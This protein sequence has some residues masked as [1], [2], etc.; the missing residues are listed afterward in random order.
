MKKSLITASLFLGVIF[1]SAG[2]TYAAENNNGTDY[3]NGGVATSESEVVKDGKADEVA[4]KAVDSS[5][6][7]INSD[8]EGEELGGLDNSVNKADNPE[9]LVIESAPD[10]LPAVVEV[11]GTPNTWVARNGSQYYIGSDG[12]AV[13]GVREINGTL[14]YFED[15]EGALYKNVGFLNLGDDTYYVTA[16]GAL[17]RN[18]ITN[19]RVDNIFVINRDGRLAKGLFYIGQ[20][21]YFADKV[22]GEIKKAAKW[23]DYN[24][25]RYYNLPSGILL[26]NTVTRTR[27]DNMFIFQFGGEVKK[28][29]L[30]HNGNLYYADKDTGEIKLKAQWI[31]CA[32]ERYYSKADGTLLRGVKTNTRVDNEFYFN[33]DGTVVRG[34]IERGGKKYIADPATGEIKLKA[35][36]IDYNGE[37]YYSRADGSLLTGVVTNTRVDNKFLF[38]KD[39]S[40]V[41][42]LFYIGQDR[43]FADPVTGEIKLVAQWIDYDGNR[44]YSNNQGI[45]Y[46]NRFIHFDNYSK[47][48]LTNDG[49][50]A[51]SKIVVGGE[52]YYPNP[53]TGRIDLRAP[54]EGEYPDEPPFGWI[55]RNGNTYLKNK[56]GSFAKGNV[57]VGQFRYF[58]DQYGVLRSKVVIDVSEWQGDINWH[59]VA[60]EGVQGAIIRAGYSGAAN[61]RIVEDNFFH[62]NMRE[63]IAEGVQVGVY[64]YSQ[65]VNEEE[66]KAEAR[67]LFEMSRGYNLDLPMILDMEI[68]SEENFVGRTY[69]LT[70]QQRT[71]VAKAF[72]EEIKRLGGNPMFYSYTNFLNTMVDMNQLKD[73]PVWVAQYHT[74]VTYK[75]P[76]KAWQYSSSGTVEGIEGRTDL[77]IW[78]D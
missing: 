76:Y 34:I 69:A 58:F 37:R 42:G 64:Y 35:Q 8:V 6:E 60:G 10:P 45:L 22:T 68:Y 48:Y 15:Y 50:V 67:K 39:G 33:N 14:Y 63:A 13:R 51:K 11:T 32:G 29:I 38:N 5:D 52:A 55:H 3:N 9:N 71:D 57:A 36:W 75:G 19:T 23:I 21:R 61:G 4:D 27:V 59:D 53:E 77:N 7:N 44:Y 18:L 47:Y 65:A 40:V 28:G 49:S 66:A 72:L 62:K 30:N 16:S 20:D 70:K 26:R 2:Y 25:E 56:D 78:Y 73:Y 41:R 54:E 74:E 31:D 24:G 1:L 12:K 46:R 17:L 43:Y